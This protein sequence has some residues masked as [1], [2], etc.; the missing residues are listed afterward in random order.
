MIILYPSL[1]VHRLIYNAEVWSSLT[2]SHLPCLMNAQL[3]YLRHILE[4]PKSTPVAALFLELST[5]SI[6]FETEKRQ[7]LFIM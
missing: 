7:L 1:F 2:K 5:L 4:V 6:Q 3:Q